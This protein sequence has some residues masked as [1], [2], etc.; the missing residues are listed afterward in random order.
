MKTYLAAA[1]I[2]AG[3]LLAGQASAATPLIFQD[4]EGV[5]VNA[6]NFYTE[7][8]YR[9]GAQNTGANSMYDEGTWTIGATPVDTHNLWIEDTFAS[10]KLILNGKDSGD[11]GDT[12][13]WRQE[14]AATQGK[15]AFS[16]DVFDVCCNATFFNIGGINANSILTFEYQLDGGSFVEIANVMTNQATNF[17]E[18]GVDGYRITGTFDVAP[19]GNLRVSLRSWEDAPGGNDFAVDNISITAVPEPTTWGLMILGF[20]AAGA[21]LRTSRRRMALVRA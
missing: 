2:A 9:T 1:A 14:A 5:D 16:F 10:N 19:T 12:I 7:Y 8:S 20:G 11:G 3:V 15:Y 13:A 18:N 4:F 6:P 17:V 21:A